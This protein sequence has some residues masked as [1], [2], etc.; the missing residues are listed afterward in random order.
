MLADGRDVWAF[1]GADEFVGEE[2]DVLFFEVAFVVLVVGT[3]VEGEGAGLV[4]C[5]GLAGDRVEDGA[6]VEPGVGAG[7]FGDGD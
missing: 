7:D 3:F 1:G 5:D 6:A 2:G 4:G